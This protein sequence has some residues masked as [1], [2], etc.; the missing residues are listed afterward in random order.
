[1]KGVVYKVKEEWNERR[2]REEREREKREKV[3]GRRGEGESMQGL[4]DE[5]QLGVCGSGDAMR[6][7][8]RGHS[9]WHLG[10]GGGRR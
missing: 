6:A 7:L 5:G 9:D 3:Q 10:I 8:R 4:G 1:M 2:G